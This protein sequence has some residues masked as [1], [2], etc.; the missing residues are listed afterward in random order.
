MDTQSYY[1]AL[2]IGGYSQMSSDPATQLLAKSL[3]GDPAGGGET[4]GKC[5]LCL[6]TCGDHLSPAPRVDR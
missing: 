1:Q 3:Q 5:T 6:G 2:L 4:A